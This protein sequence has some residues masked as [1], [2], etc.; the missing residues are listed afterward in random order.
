M[1]LNR[2][3]R[4]AARYEGVSPGERPIFRQSRCRGLLRSRSANQQLVLVTLHPYQ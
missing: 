3:R 4:Y 2:M 1:R